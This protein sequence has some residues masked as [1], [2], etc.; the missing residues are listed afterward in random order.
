MTVSTTDTREVKAG[1]GTTKTFPIG[2]EFFEAADLEVTKV[3]TDGSQV[4]WTL[5]SEYTISGGGGSTGSLTTTQGNTLKSGEKLAIRRLTARTQQLDLVSNDILPAEDLEDRY[6]RTVFVTQEVAEEASRAAKAPVSDPAGV[7]LILPAKDD[8]KNKMLGFDSSGNPKVKIP[9]DVLETTDD[10]PEGSSN[11]YYTAERARDDVGAAIVAGNNLT[12]TVDDANDT[13]TLFVDI[14]DTDTVPEGGTNLYF[15]DE[16]AQDAVASMLAGGSGIATNYDD[17]ND[18]FTIDADLGTGLTFSSGQIVV[19][20]GDGLEASSGA[21]QVDAGPGLQLNNQK[22]EVNQGDGLAFNGDVLEVDEGNGLTFSSGQLTVSAGNGL[23]FD[24]GGQVAV[25]LATDG[26][27]QFNTG[28]LQVNTGGGLSLDSTGVKANLG[29]GLSLSSDNIQVNLGDG[30]QL[31]NDDV[32]VDN[33]V[34]RTPGTVARTDANNVFDNGVNG[35]QQTIKGGTP[36]LFLFEDDN[37]DDNARIEVINNGTYTI[38]QVEDNGSNTQATRWQTNL[39]TGIH[40]AQGGRIQSTGAPTDPNDAATKQY[41]DDNTTAAS[42][43]TI[44]ASSNQ[45][46]SLD[47]GR[48]IDLTLQADIS[49]AFSD[50]GTPDNLLLTVRQDST[51]GRQLTFL[52]TVEWPHGT[53]PDLTSDANAIDVFQFWTLDGGSTWFANLVSADAK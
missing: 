3:N 16:R 18:V 32:A 53:K 12:K 30:L 10:L 25:N 5:N 9:E 13:I 1:N 8:R 35:G 36:N 44:N 40:D 33:T 45:N 46:I 20:A 47:D 23:Q 52:D 26:G 4:T 14:T 34:V 48:W 15:T 49:V 21:V 50:A 31:S 38:K 24:G 51:G 19:V 7:Q 42:V 22:V 43:Q 2:F 41:V 37:P 6:D 29:D 11:L 17:A 27:L 39:T 28:Q